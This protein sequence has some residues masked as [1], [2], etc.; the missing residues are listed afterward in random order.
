MR[1]P[2]MRYWIMRRYTIKRTSNSS[3]KTERT[4]ECKRE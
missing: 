2:D 3:L 4:S 1:I